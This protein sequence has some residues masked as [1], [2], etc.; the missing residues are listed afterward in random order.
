MYSEQPTKFFADFVR[1][2]LSGVAKIAVRGIAKVVRARFYHGA[3]FRLLLIFALVVILLGSAFPKPCLSANAANFPLVPVGNS[4]IF[5][6]V[7][8]KR[9]FEKF[10]RPTLNNRSPRWVS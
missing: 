4:A 7:G 1:C 9:K 2:K 6:V 8:S 10:L 5:G 3:K